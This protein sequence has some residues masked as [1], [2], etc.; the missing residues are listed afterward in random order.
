MKSEFLHQQSVRHS[1][2][3][4]REQPVEQSQHSYLDGEA[5]HGHRVEERFQPPKSNHR[6]RGHKA[7]RSIANLATYQ[8]ICMLYI[9]KLSL[10]NVQH[11]LHRSRFPLL[12]SGEEWETLVKLDDQLDF[13]GTK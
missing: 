10:A 5:W 2:Y 8:R 6:H 12:A 13:H 4:N 11:D 3:Q 7:S 1:T 9:E